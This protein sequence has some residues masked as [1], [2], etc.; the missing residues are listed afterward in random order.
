MYAVHVVQQVVVGNGGKVAELEV[1]DV[2]RKAFLNLLLDEAVHHGIGLSAAR[3]TQYD[4]GT[5]RVYHIDIAIVPLLPVVETC[6]QIDGIPVLHEAGL[7]HEA[8]V[9]DIEHVFHEVGMQKAAHPC[10]RHE[11]ADI[12]RRH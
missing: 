4:G 5:E 8:L 1:V 6:G 2:H 7:L 3:R 9:L 11:Q 12:A 10:T